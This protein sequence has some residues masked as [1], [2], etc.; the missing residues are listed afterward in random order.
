ML[1]IR[2]SRSGVRNHPFYRIVATDERAPI[3]G[4]SLETIGYWSPGQKIKKINKEA[5]AKWLKVGA[6]VTSAVSK[7]LKD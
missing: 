3:K 7:I 6:K 5:L 2:L 1:K 4:K